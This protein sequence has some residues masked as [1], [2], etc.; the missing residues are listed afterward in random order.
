MN[1]KHLIFEDE[2]TP[3]P[4][5]PN[6]VIPLKPVPG[7]VPVPASSR[8]NVA[9]AKLLEKTAFETTATG[10]TFMKYL[11]PLK[12]LPIDEHAKY[13]A[14]VAQASAQE[15]LTVERI[16]ATF[17]GLQQALKDE[18]QHFAETTET[19]SQ[20]QVG[21]KK[22]QLSDLQAQIATLTAKFGDLNREIDAAQSKIESAKQQFQDAVNLRASELNEQKG[23]YT[24]LLKG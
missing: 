11:D 18:T 8:N 24:T 20:Q 10:A 9:Y 1:I 23:K 3:P 4:K 19:W 21:D 22:R 2:D 6:A 14:A 5:K 13:K 7:P 12:G 16:L 17:D 15:G